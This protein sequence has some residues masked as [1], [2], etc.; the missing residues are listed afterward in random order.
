MELTRTDVVF[1]RIAF[2]VFLLCRVQKFAEN[3]RKIR[4]SI[5]EGKESRSQGGTPGAGA[6]PTRGWG[7]GRDRGSPL[8]LG[9][10]LSSP[11]RLE[12]SFRPKINGPEHFF[13][14]TLRSSTAIANPKFGV[15]DRC[16]GTLPEWRLS[17]SSPPMPLHRPSMIPPSRCE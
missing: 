7:P 1:S 17:P 10:R 16:S 8:P 2:G 12:A 9:P 4:K 3:S 15:Q 5:F 13:Q 14:K 6:G 11:L